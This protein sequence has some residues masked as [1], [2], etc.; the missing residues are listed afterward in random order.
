MEGVTTAIVGFIFLC[1]AF[2]NLIKRA[3]PFYIAIAIVPVVLFWFA[4]AALINTAGFHQAVGF[5][6]GLLLIVAFI[7][8][9]LATGGMSL[10]QLTGGI[11]GAFTPAPTAPPPPTMAPPGEAPQAAPAAPPRKQDLGSLPLE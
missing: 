1:I 8:L 9:V 7:L 4:L 10:G 11:F 3:A 2:P 5:I 6:V